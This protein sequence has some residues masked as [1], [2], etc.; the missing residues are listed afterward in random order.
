MSHPYVASIWQAGI[1]SVGQQDILHVKAKKHTEGR[2]VA[3]IYRGWRYLES[4]ANGKKREA[5]LKKISKP[6][7][8]LSVKILFY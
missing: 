1:K 7:K 2:A 4:Q 6:S 5:C 8:R 3:E